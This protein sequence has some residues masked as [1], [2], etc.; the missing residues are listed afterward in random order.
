M[1][2]AEDSLKQK[3]KQQQYKILKENFPKIGREKE[4]ILGEKPSNK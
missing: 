4:S 1:R 2:V 3:G